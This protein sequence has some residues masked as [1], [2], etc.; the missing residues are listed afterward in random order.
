MLLASCDLCRKLYAHHATAN[1]EHIA[2]GSE[3]S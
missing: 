1:D 3:L 2:C